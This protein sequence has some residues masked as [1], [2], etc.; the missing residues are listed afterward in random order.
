MELGFTSLCVTSLMSM[1]ATASAE[2][3]AAVVPDTIGAAAGLTRIECVPDDGAH[4][5]RFRGAIIDTG[6]VDFP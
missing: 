3:A 1:L 6:T 5:H 4:T 2:A